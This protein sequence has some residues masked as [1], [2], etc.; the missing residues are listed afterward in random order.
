ML[1]LCTYVHTHWETYHHQQQT[2]TRGIIFWVINNICSNRMHVAGAE[3][4]REICLFAIYSTV[5]KQRQ[6]VAKT[7]RTKNTI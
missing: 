3:R 7:T 6:F 2:H 1:G 5:L 4:I